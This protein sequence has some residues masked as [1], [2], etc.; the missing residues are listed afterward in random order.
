MEAVYNLEWTAVYSFAFI[1]YLHEEVRTILVFI[2]DPLLL[3]TL[4]F[5]KTVFFSPPPL[6][7]KLLMKLMFAIEFP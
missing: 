4:V 5:L 1:K 2:S 6:S 3:E 7:L